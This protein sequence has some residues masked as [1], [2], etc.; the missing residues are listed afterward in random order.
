MDRAS[1]IVEEGYPLVLGGIAFSLTTLLGPEHA[2]KEFYEAAT[3]VL[4]VLLLALAIEVRLLGIR[5]FREVKFPDPPVSSDEVDDLKARL[6]SKEQTL[7]WAREERERMRP[8]IEKLQ[9]LPPDSKIGEEG[10]EI[11]AREMLAQMNNLDEQMAALP[12]QLGEEQT[13]VARLGRQV[14]RAKREALMGKTSLVFRL[15]YA[16]GGAA[17]LACAELYALVTLANNSSASSDASLVLGGIVFGVVALA[18]VAL[19]YPLD[20]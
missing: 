6:H 5:G 1:R 19:R 14:K 9:A 18:I 4:A 12:D 3:Q 15:I 13:S 17:V 11:T 8:A 2:E 10:E 16:I 20:S 7:R